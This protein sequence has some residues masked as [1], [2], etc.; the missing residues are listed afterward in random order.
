MI[1]CMAQGLNGWFQR[2]PCRNVL[3]NLAVVPGP[4]LCFLKPCVSCTQSV[5]TW[6]A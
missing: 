5:G 2:S 4:L 6:G 1:F 3:T